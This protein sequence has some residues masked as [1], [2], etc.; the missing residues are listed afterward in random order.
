ASLCLSL[1]DDDVVDA[2][3][4]RV[5]PRRFAAV[6]WPSHDVRRSYAAMLRTAVMA[7]VALPLAVAGGALM[8]ARLGRVDMLPPPVVSLVAALEPWHL[9]SSSGLFS[10]MTRHRPE[11]ILEGSDDG[12]HG[13][14]YPFRWKPGDVARRPRF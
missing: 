7:A 14:E 3:L 1:L 6:R 2:M 10:V 12:Q 11:I 5:V 13:V 8:V 4:D 9:T